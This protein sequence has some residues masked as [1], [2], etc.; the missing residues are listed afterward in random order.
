VTY[1][2]GVALFAL[3]ILLSLTLHEVGHAVAA[4]AFGMKVTRFFI[5]FGPTLFSFR[6][7]GVEYGVKAI[8]AGAFV[9]IVGMTPLDDVAPADEPRAMWRFPVWKR[10]VVMSAGVITHFALGFLI[11]WGLFAFTPLP[12]DGLLQSEPV[13]VAT[14]SPC[15]QTRWSVDPATGRERACTI[16]DD[17]ASAAAQL[18]IQPG[19]VILAIDGQPVR[20]WDA[21]TTTVRAAGGR[22]VELT[23]ERAGQRQTASVV[24]P[25][26]ERVRPEALDRSAGDIT[27]A[28]LEQVGMLGV[29]PQIPTSTAGPVA[30]IGDA[31]AQAAALFGATFD[32]LLRLPAKVPALWAS[33]TGDERD[34]EAPVS[35][36][37]ASHIGGELAGRGDW[38]SFLLMLA[39]LNFF[40]GMFNLLPVLPADGGHIAIGWFERTRS[41]LYARLSRPDPG[42]VDYYRLAP[43]ALGAI[44]LFAAF[45]LL[46]VTADLINPVHLTD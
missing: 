43:I 41:W 6:R 36:V 45:T 17:P 9:K 20:G 28:D 3:G 8:P 19:D 1:G 29:T 23:Y 33:I 11:L 5:G 13:R 44:I 2:V 31:G 26:V 18:G 39:S 7:R 34:P 32:A 21:M 40:I 10:T 46:S 27:A 38:Q 16:G 12:D 30:A 14:V 37:G 35:M 25:L 15:V 22:S 24:L 4:R 42:P